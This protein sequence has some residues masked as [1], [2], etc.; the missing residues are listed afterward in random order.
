MY[1]TYIMN[2]KQKS[3]SSREARRQWRELLDAVQTDAASFVIERYG[4]PVA[5]IVPYTETPETKAGTLREAVA[6]YTA[7][8]EAKMETSNA[9]A[10]LAALQ[11]A[12]QNLPADALPLL[13]TIVHFLREQSQTTAVSQP[14]TQL[15]GWSTL[16]PVGYAGDALADSEAF[17]DDV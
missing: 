5:R 11:S 8:E 9:E 6:L 1:T 16:L 3:V 14:A 2:T 10:R 12:L 15:D 17:Y 7:T 13:E 4:K